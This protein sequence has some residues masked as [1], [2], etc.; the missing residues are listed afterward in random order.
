MLNIQQIEKSWGDKKVL[1]NVSLIIETG[2]FYGLLGPNGAG[3]TTLIS[4][5]AGLVKANSGLITVDGYNLKNNPKNYRN[6]IG[7]VPQEIA[8]YETLSA[9]ENILF[10][11]STYGLD[12]KI[13]TERAHYFLEMCGLYERRNEKIKNYSG[14]MKRRINIVASLIHHPSLLLLDEPTVGIDP[15]SRN[16]IFEILEEVNKG[17]TTIVYTSHYM[18]EVERLCS[19]IAIIDHG[20]I[21]ANGKIEELQMQNGHISHIKI[22][23]NTLPLNTERYTFID[24][25]TILFKSKNP[26]NDLSIII[27][28]LKDDNAEVTDVHIEKKSL[29]HIFLDLT[30]KHLRD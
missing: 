7:I 19:N 1:D 17:G 4:I 25:N 13:S 21:K 6:S 14:G 9:I 10:F 16:K 26:N 30:G 22:K 24:K 11:A 12:K 29:E 18:E 2:C 28:Q 3:K 8:L 23:V 15:Q 27:Q 5:I 20:Q